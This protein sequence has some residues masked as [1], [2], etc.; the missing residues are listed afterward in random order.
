MGDLNKFI[1]MGRLAS[2]PERNEVGDSAVCVFTLVTN[3][4]LKKKDGRKYE[5]TAFIK[6]E[7]W[8]T[9]GDTIA[10]HFR[11]GDPI[12]IEGRIRQDQW[13]DKEGNKRSTLKVRVD[14]FQFVPKTSGQV[15][16]T[17]ES[18]E[19]EPEEAVEAEF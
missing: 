18:V 3:T 11:K 13:T 9:G 19:T 10:K 17:N 5:D 8:D 16:R 7:A 15:N 4:S 6:C 2:D 14:Q 1:A 12:L